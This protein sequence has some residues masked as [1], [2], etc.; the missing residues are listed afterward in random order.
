M[1]IQCHHHNIGLLPL[2]RSVRRVCTL[3]RDNVVTPGSPGK[4]A[5][6]EEGLRVSGAQLWEAALRVVEAPALV[7]YFRTGD[8]HRG[9]ALEDGGEAQ[10][11]FA[12][13]SSIRVQ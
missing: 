7:D 3:V 5:V 13:K 8:S 6:E 9:V 1:D 11:V 4:K 12:R 2:V 10:K